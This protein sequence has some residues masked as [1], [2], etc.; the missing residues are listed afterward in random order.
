MSIPRTSCSARGQSVRSANRNAARA[1]HL[2]QAKAKD[3]AGNPTF[4]VLHQ[5]AE[6]GTPISVPHGALPSMHSFRHLAD[7]RVMRPAEPFGLV[8]AVRVVILS[9]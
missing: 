2:A 6:D 4:P 7:A 3:D 8:R 9:A 1:L 5:R